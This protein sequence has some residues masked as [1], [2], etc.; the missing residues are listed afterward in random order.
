M[1]TKLNFD[2]HRF[3]LN[4]RGTNREFLELD[5]HVR[6]LVFNVGKNDA[7]KAEISECKKLEKRRDEMLNNYIQANA[8]APQVI[9]FSPQTDPNTAKIL[10]V[11][12]AKF[13]NTKRKNIVMVGAVGT[14]KTYCAKIMAEK[15]KAAGYLVH[16]SSV[17]S[18]IKRM[19][20]NSFGAD[21]TTDRDFFETDLLIIDDLGAEPEHKNSGEYLYTVIAER[22]ENN[23]PFIITTNLSAEH[24]MNK[25][26]QRVAGRIFDKHKTAVIKFDG[27]D[28]RLG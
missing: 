12:C 16:F 21:L 8:P 18:L 27:E 24:L 4:L 7:T 15:L 25:Y 19:R 2:R 6:E 28:M 9:E 13:P 3:L 5:N 20:E 1:Q 22:Y 17:Y 10:S 14:G 11:F 23:L 26:D